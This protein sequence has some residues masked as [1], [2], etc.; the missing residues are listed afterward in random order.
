MV[1]FT[2][3]ALKKF[4]VL[5][6]HKFSVSKKQVLKAATKPELTD[7][8]RT[9]LLIGQ[10]SID[11]THVLRV[12]YKRENGNIKIITFYPGRKNQYEKK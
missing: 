11:K 12:V 9:P 1:I 6:R 2:K 7:Y 4:T 3:H 8:S 10:V 5:K